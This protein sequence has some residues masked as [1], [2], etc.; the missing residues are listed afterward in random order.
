MAAAVEVK[1]KQ[2]NQLVG[3]FIVIESA[4]KLCIM[5]QWFRVEDKISPYEGII[6][7][8]HQTHQLITIMEHLVGMKPVD[9]YRLMV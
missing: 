6:R 3:P 4:H 2:D 9:N 1:F 8:F 7:G 5:R